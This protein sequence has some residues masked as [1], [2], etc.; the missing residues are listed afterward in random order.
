MALLTKS[1]R[2]VIAESISL[3]A[4]HFAWGSGDGAWTTTVPAEDPEATTLI[5]EL[6]RRTADAVSF[7]LPDA[8]GS[9]VLPAGNF[10]L[11]GSPTRYL[12][13]RTK[14]AFADA[15]SSVIREMAVF[16]GSVMAGGLPVGQRYFVP[17]DVSSPGR[18]LHL[19]HFQPI[20]R[21]SVIEES[22]EVVVTF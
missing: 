10:T 13:C 1:G 11:S 3:R 19:E 14:F 15:P 22:F 4:V 6:G 20:Y 12:Y 17:A 8:A 9:I 7:V 5:S 16:V 18:M 21:S 2:I